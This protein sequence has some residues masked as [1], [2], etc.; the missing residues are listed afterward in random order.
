MRVRPALLLTLTTVF[1]LSL[2]AGEQAYVRRGAIERQ[3]RVWV[4]RAE[5]GASV[6]PGG[7]LRV[8]LDLGSVRVEPGPDDR[9]VCRVLLRTY[10]GSEAEAKRRFERYELSIHLLDGGAVL[11][12]RLRGARAPSAP[13]AYARPSSRTPPEPPSPPSPPALPPPPD[14]PLNVEFDIQVPLRFDI[15]IETR[16]GDLVVERLQGQ[17]RGA[18]AGGDIRTGDVSGQ[19]RAVTAGG[20]IFLGNVGQQAEATTA[21]GNILV[22]NVQGD[23]T[24]ET[25]GGKIVAG[26]IAGTVRAVT[27]GG[28]VLLRG[29]GGDVIA[30]TAG[31]L[32][33]IGE[34]GGYVRAQ[35]AGGSIKLES[36]RGLVHVKTAGGSILLYQVQSGVEAAT[37]AGKIVA[38]IAASPASFKASVLENSFGD[39]E[40]YLPP[41]L[42]IT[43][44][45]SIAMAAGYQIHTDFPLQI[46]G[47]Q[48][49]FHQSTLRG[50]G[51]LNG[52]GEVLR[53]RTQA[54]NIKIFKLDTQSRQELREGQKS[55]WK[56]WEKYQ[57]KLEQYR[58]QLEQKDQS[59]NPP[60]ENRTL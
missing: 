1:G 30:E 40:V 38:R 57:K 29:A 18:T 49:S 41:D 39:V 20:S 53:I 8:R 21:G 16:G 56:Y 3:G 60:G 50:R 19:V 14:V 4:E 28:D 15:D 48:K 6:R 44:D 43:I 13:S 22:G 37:V 52:G 54:G 26:R 46:Q 2:A 11:R 27:A 31:G 47:G 24:L 55:L 36:A 10:A 45:A 9:M 51:A 12:G 33:Q 59:Q 7:H 34:T 58:R 35:T 32:I 42:P 25:S 23:A 17:F 5:C